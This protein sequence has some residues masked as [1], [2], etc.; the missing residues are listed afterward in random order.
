VA[1]K[2][3]MNRARFLAA[4]TIAIGSPIPR[5]EAQVSLMRADSILLERTGCYGFCP[6][7]Q[8]RIAKSGE[9]L[10]RTGGRVRTESGEDVFR[11]SA[12]AQKRSVGPG[13]F[14]DLM[15]AATFLH[16]LELP[17]VIERDARFCPHR[18]TDHPS[19]IVTIF[20]GN[21]SKRVE[22]YL[23]CDWAPAGLRRL[24][25]EIDS[26]AGTTTPLC[27]ECQPPHIGHEHS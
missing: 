27:P 16:F 13:K 10:V 22:D 11:T 5:V 2:F 20:F 9:V 25:A 14:L 24:E 21:Q 4:I 19:A 8:L 6:Q 12:P 15:T 17:D 18:W 26:T 23:G 7:Y 3:R 1:A